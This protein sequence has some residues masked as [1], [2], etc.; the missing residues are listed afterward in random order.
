MA[1]DDSAVAAACVCAPLRICSSAT[2]IWPALRLISCTALLSSSAAE[3]TSSALLAM[4]VEFFSSSAISDRLP[5]VCSHSASAVPCSSTVL[6]AS[7]QALLCSAAAEAICSAPF[8]A[9]CEA[10]LLWPAADAISVAPA[11][12]SAAS[13]RICSS[14]LRMTP[15]FSTS[16]WMPSAASLMPPAMTLTSPW[17]W[18]TS[19]WICLALF[20][21]VSARVR[22]S[23][24][25]TAKPLPCWPAR[26]ASMAAFSASRLVWSAMRAT[27]LTMSPM[28]AAWRSSSATI[29]TLSAWRL[30]ATPTLV[31]VLCTSWL[32]R[33]ASVCMTSALLC[34]SVAAP[35]WRVMAPPTCVMAASDSCAAPEASSAPVA[36]W[37]VARLSSSA[38][39]AASLMPLDS[40][41]DAL[42]TRSAACCCLASVRARLRLASASRV[43]VLVRP[44]ATTAGGVAGLAAAGRV[45]VTRDMEIS[46][47]LVGTRMDGAGM[48]RLWPSPVPWVSTCRKSVWD[49]AARARAHGR[50]RAP[51][52]AAGCSNAGRSWA[53]VQAAR[54]AVRSGSW[55]GSWAT[56]S[57]RRPQRGTLEPDVRARVALQ[58]VWVCNGDWVAFKLT[59]PIVRSV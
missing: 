40:W 12:I 53:P 10:T 5:E 42:A 4:S 20:S 32:M 31:T 25:T 33:P 17:I 34:A 58:A 59:R 30:A 11:T 46:G 27:A 19:S 44:L 13:M 56:S 43:M 23:S 48:P 8:R 38:A 15:L 35:S 50:A 2:M 55:R 52:A 41:L 1:A 6:A 14:C 16:P 29:F 39:D 7:S 9:C 57:S 21:L 47:G 49:K 24:A 54:R 36:I 3:A 37:S 45:L 51:R 18:P 26:A 28:L 22:T